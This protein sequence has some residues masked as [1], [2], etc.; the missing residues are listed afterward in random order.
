MHKT[1]SK[2]LF[3]ADAGVLEELEEDDDLKLSQEELEILDTILTSP[4]KAAVEDAGQPKNSS[5]GRGR[6]RGKG[7]GVKAKGKKDA[8]ADG[9]KSRYSRR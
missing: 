3:S 4:Q 1:L 2:F 6:G 5:R 7:R 8:K 9:K